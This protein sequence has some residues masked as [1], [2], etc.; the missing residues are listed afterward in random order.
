M[1]INDKIKKPLLTAEDQIQHLKDKEITFNYITEDDAKNYLL[2]N[3]NLFK[4]SSYRKN[5]PKKTEN[6]QNKYIS[7][8]FAYLK[9]MAIIDMNLRYVIIQLSLDIEHYVK[10][11]L[12]R[13][14][15][16]N[17]ENGYSICNDYINNLSETQYSIL[18]GELERCKNS[19]YC[20]DLTKSYDI[21]LPN[22]PCNSFL[23]IPLWVFLEIIPFGRLVDFYRFCSSRFNNKKMGKMYFMLLQSKELRN[24]CAHSSCVLNDLTPNIPNKP[25]SYAVLNSLSKIKTIS[26]ITREKKMS[27]A[28]IRQIVTLLYVHT[29]IVTSNGVHKKSALLLNSFVQRMLK[30][31]T[32]YDQCD[33]ISTTFHFL[34]IIIDNWF[35]KM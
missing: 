6:G 10:M 8:D 24:A 12:L 34:K 3:N 5:F 19:I 23:K 22:Y 15:E 27:N 16:S 18:K 7:L 4:L 1:M 9:D 28:R 21:I 25:A 2:Y 31:I 33:T 35:P 26:D 14:A 32:Y 30:N 17:K 13:S 11:E 20:S 29:R